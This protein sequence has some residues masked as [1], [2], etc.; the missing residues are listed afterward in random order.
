MTGLAFFVTVLLA[1]A[2]E[3][4]VKPLTDDLALKLVKKAVSFDKARPKRKTT[5]VTRR[6]EPEAGKGA[7][8]EF[9]WKEDKAVR[10]GLAIVLPLSI[11]DPPSPWLAQQDGWGLVAIH[12]DKTL[13]QLLEEMKRA[14]VAANEAATVGDIRTVISAQAVYQ[15][16]NGGFYGEP[17][18]LSGPWD[19]IPNYARS[20]PALLPD[21]FMLEGEKSGYKRRFHAGPQGAATVVVPK[22]TR[23]R[24][25]KPSPTPPP[26]PPFQGLT[27]FAVTAVPLAPGESG[28]RGFCG[29]A[30]GRIC[31]T[32]DGQE[33]AVVEGNCAAACPTLP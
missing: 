3:T 7:V 15:N 11:G 8:L 28:V 26:P 1:A 20:Q 10:T 9:Q 5:Q 12:E 25:K 23:R 33:P 27:S 14:R 13:A 18:C 31:F 17:P 32:A 29:D 6:H 16:A 4:R 19:C 22:P 2:P 30:S 24:G 21:G